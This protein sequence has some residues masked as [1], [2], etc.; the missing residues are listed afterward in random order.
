MNPEMKHDVA[1]QV[2]QYLFMFKN[3]VEKTIDAESHLL[4][5]TED[6]VLRDKVR[7]YV[8]AHGIVRE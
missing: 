5:R 3:G 2:W 8:R 6:H 4:E 1:Y 7:K